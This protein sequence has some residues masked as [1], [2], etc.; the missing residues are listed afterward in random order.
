MLDSMLEKKDTHSTQLDLKLL[1]DKYKASRD[2]SLREE[3]VRNM[4][5]LIKFIAYKYSRDPNDVED[6]IQVGAIGLLKA[7][8]R[9]DPSKGTDFKAYAIPSITGEI[10]RYFRDNTWLIKVP[11]RLKELKYKIDNIVPK[12]Y[13]TLGRAPTISEI[14]NSLGVSKEEIIEATEL[15]Y[16][17]ISLN[18]KPNS[19]A[20]SPTE[21]ITLI[22][23]E[24][25]DFEKF[26]S[27]KDLEETLNRLDPMEKYVIYMKFFYGLSQE[28]I[29]KKLN[30]SQMTV[31]RIQS[32]ALKKLHQLCK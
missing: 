22:N 26:Q 1:I 7:L 3:I 23:K 14:A 11:R 13:A 25:K 9:F 12:L 18:S 6:L 17:P 30:V 5:P 8:E 21:L 2:P 31:S 19:D 10:K 15:S 32:R 24:A 4:L 16:H 20:E 28:E 29:A 27:L